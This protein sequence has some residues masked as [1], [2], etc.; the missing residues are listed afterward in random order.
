MATETA[1]EITQA[2][3]EPAEPA[4]PETPAP[5]TESAPETPETTDTGGI[6]PEL[7]SQ[8]DSRFA[9]MRSDLGLDAPPTGAQ[10]T[11]E[12]QPHPVEQIF[13][14]AQPLEEGEAGGDDSYDQ[15]A[16]PDEEARREVEEYLNQKAQEAAE[17]QLAPF[18]E[19]EQRR[20]RVEA[21]MALEDEFPELRDSR[22]AGPVVQLGQA[23]LAEMGIPEAANHPG[24]AK[25]CKVLYMASKAEAA[26][27]SET[28]A[29][30][31]QEVALEQPGARAPSPAQSEPTLQ[32][33]I[34]GSG[35][36][37]LFPTR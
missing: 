26:A 37:G 24:F 2:P 5:A 30:E 28:P 19:Q 17:K 20:Q 21:A 25:L 16:D 8:I 9:E 3:A 11:E 23:M 36:P 15:Y 32:E 27:S 31:G 18:F 7:A 33:Q 1:E 35:S 12:Q 22:V 10:G 29:G 6:S 4:A 34:V 13:P 14:A